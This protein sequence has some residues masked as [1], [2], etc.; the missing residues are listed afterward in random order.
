M[1]PVYTIP[2]VY[3]I[4][5]GE[6]EGLNL[7][8][9]AIFMAYI[10]FTSLLSLNAYRIKPD[11]T[12]KQTLIIF[13]QW[14]VYI[15]IIVIVGFKKITWGQGD[16]VVSVAVLI[17]SAITI[18]KYK[19]FK[20]PYSK[21]LLAVWCKS[22]PQLW[23]AYTIILAGSGSG[24]PL[25][26]LLAGHLTSIPR[27]VQVIISGRG[28]WDRPSKGLLLGELGNVATWTVVTIAWAYFKIF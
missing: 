9:Y 8:I 10:L 23:L 1:A 13:S 22:V 24:M 5:N 7:A 16:T 25:V 4:V 27:L 21:G 26:T 12:R 28:S 19:G 20:D 17:L 18:F 11:I 6:V 3:K 15:G 2:Q 14:A